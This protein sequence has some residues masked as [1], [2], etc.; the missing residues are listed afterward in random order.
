MS[1]TLL[2]VCD[3]LTIKALETV[4]KRLVRADRSRFKVMS[5]RPYHLAHTIWTPDDAEVAKSLRGAWDVA[6]MLIDRHGEEHSPTAVTV[7]LNEYVHDLCITGTP[8]TVEELAYRFHA[9]LHDH[10]PMEESHG[11]AV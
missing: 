11:S 10:E 9:R 2:A 1:E 3:V 7:M 8:H 6:K 5:G 4:G